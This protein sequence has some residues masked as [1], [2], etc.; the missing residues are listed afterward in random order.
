MERSKLLTLATLVT[1]ILS[2]PL[3]AQM[4]DSGEGARNRNQ[5]GGVNLAP[6][7]PVRQVVSI[8]SYGRVVKMRDANG[9]TFD[10]QVGEGIYDLSKLKIGEKVQVNFLEP[11]GLG[12]HKVKAANIWPVQ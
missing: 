8:D 12:S 3:Q 4:R 7:D 11:D 9:K 6:S 10:V 2:A 1:L 5:G